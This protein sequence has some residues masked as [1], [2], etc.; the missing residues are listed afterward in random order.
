M[1]GMPGLAEQPDQFW[2]P[3]GVAVDAENR[4]YVTDTGNNRVAVFDASGKFLTQFGSNGINPGEFDEP[5]GIAVGSDGLVFVA[6]TW[7]QRIQVFQADGVSAFTFLREWTVNAW[8]GQSINNKPFLA[9]DGENNVYITDPDGYRV[10]TFDA[11]GEFLRGWGAPSSGI[12]G[13]GI[14]TGIAVD[15]DGKV[16]VTDA[17]NNFALRFT[18]PADTVVVEEEVVDIPVVPAGLTYDAASDRLYNEFNMPGYRLGTDRMEWIPLV[19]ESIT[20]LVSLGTEPV[21]NAAGNWELLSADGSSLFEWDPLTYAW[22]VVS[23]TP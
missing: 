11:T 15:A 22:V 9:L 14:P 16:W 17:E 3:R 20:G 12:D 5:V 23:T 1:W 2:G 8:F 13:F 18:L 6:D 19:P 4:V 10:L 7:N 21:K